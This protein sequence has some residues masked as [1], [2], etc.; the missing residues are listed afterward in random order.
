ML[1]Y[2]K[3]SFLKASGLFNYIQKPTLY[4]KNFSSGS[5]MGKS[6]G[7]STGFK[8]ITNAKIEVE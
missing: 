6:A 5:K 8:W 1:V 3:Q 2:F 7:V 4:K